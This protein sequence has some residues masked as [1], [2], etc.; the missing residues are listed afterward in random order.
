MKLRKKRYSS[1]L[2]RGGRG[3]NRLVTLLQQ[4]LLVSS[5]RR[6]H[7]RGKRSSIFG[8][9][10]KVLPVHEKGG[11]PSYVGLEGEGGKKRESLLPRREKRKG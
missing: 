6:G 5:T 1:F 2:Y 10:P 11:T 8:C 4:D 3:E 7:R 9:S